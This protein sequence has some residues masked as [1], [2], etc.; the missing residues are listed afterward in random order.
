MH[1]VSSVWNGLSETLGVTQEVI[2]T[3]RATRVWYVKGAF[4]LRHVRGTSGREVRV[5]CPKKTAGSIEQR[6]KSAKVSVPLWSEYLNIC[7]RV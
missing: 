6:Q 4:A 7:V 3:L 2:A 5:K 1:E